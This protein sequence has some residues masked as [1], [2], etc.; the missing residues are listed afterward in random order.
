MCPGMSLVRDTIAKGPVPGNLYGAL[1]LFSYLPWPLPWAAAA[2]AATA[3]GTGGCRRSLFAVALVGGAVFGRVG[4]ARG[5][6]LSGVLM[7]PVAVAGRHRGLRCLRGTRFPVVPRAPSQVKIP[8]MT[9][10]TPSTPPRMS[11]CRPR[12][13]SGSGHDP[14]QPEI[15]VPGRIPGYECPRRLIRNKRSRDRHAGPG[16]AQWSYGPA[17]V[18]AAPRL[19]ATERSGADLH[20][21]KT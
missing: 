6:V 17:H 16:I 7:C 12:P 2:A 8:A 19:E 15:H 10:S 13:N 18:A 1:C 9:S 11:A 5:V 20:W 21:G 3:A 4:L 14:E